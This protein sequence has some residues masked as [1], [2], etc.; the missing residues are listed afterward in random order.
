[1]SENSE[2]HLRE[3]LWGNIGALD[4][5]KYIIATFL[6][7]IGPYPPKRV[8]EELAVEDSTGT[9]TPVWYETPQVRKEYGAK[10]VG[11]VNAKEN[12]YVI[13]LA[14][15]GDNYDP[16]TGGLANLLADIAGNAYDLLY[17]DKLKL[18]DLNFPKTWTSAFP[19]PKFGLEGVRELTQTT[20]YRRP[21]VGAIMKPN[22]GLDAK[23]MAKMAYEIALGGVDLLK[24]DEALVN[25]KYCPL[26]ERVVRVMEALDK[27]KAETGKKALYAFNI[28][29]D[30][31]D[32][33]MEA[34]DLVLKHGGNHLMI[35][36]AYTG[37]GGIR[38]LAEDPSIKVPIHVHRC[39][40]G[41]ISRSPFHGFDAVLISKLGRMAGADEMH[42]GS[43]EGKFHYT[44]AEMVRHMV[45]FRTE[46]HN[47]KPTFPVLS[48]ANHPGN[49]PASCCLVGNDVCL[50]AGGG[51]LGHPTSLTAGSKAMMQ[52][53][54]AYMRGVPLEEYAKDHEELQAAIKLW[55]VKK[56]TSS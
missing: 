28:T 36:Y 49:L 56:I 38:R 46:W 27:A 5:D 52:A 14:V 9:W 25:P 26:E 48:A 33:M 3:L 51:I 18:M 34:A 12:M 7:E 2:S 35:C 19:G 44:P 37:Y 15:N 50:F 32:K 16:E 6:A 13:Q 17:V 31:Q 30:R 10:I 20:S 54:D 40:H 24:D 47:F 11:L 42:A 39:G 53:A 45:T 29:M 55:G 21:V 1:L 22:V 4:P 23:T 43:I 8:A 41:A